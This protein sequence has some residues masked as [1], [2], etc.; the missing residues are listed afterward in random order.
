MYTPVLA[1]MLAAV[2]STT[3]HQSVNNPLAR[4]GHSQIDRVLVVPS[5]ESPPS[6]TAVRALSKRSG[7]AVSRL[8]L[9]E[10]LTL[11]GARSGLQL[12]FSP[13]FFPAEA[14]ISCDCAELTVSEALEEMLKG[15]DLRYLVVVDHVLI[16]AADPPID[17]VPSLAL[18][19]VATPAAGDV[20][21]TR[22]R[23]RSVVR[24][25][26]I[27]GRVFDSRTLQPIGTAQVFIPATGIGVLTRAD[28]TYALANVP[29]GPQTVQVQ[30]I[31]YAVASQIVDVAT[32]QSF[33]V[34]FELFRE[35]L[36]LNEIVVTG[37]AGGTQRRAVGNVVERMDLGQIRETSPAAT[38][39]QA[40][41]AKVP[42]M[43]VIPGSG[44][45]GG[46][47]AAIRIR[48][49]SSA[50]LPNDP[51]IYVDGIRINSDRA[52]AGSQSAGSRLNDINPADIESIEVI[53]GPAAATLYGTEASNGV[54]QIIT[55]R[56]Q[57]GAMVIDASVETGAAWF[58]DPENRI[59]TNYGRHPVTGELI[60][61]N[62]YLS[63][64]E[65]LGRDLYQRGP[66]RRYNLSARGGTDA[67]Q[68]FISGGNSYREGIVHWNW[69]KNYNGRGS[70]TVR[71]SESFAT[72]VNFSY[73]NGSNR[74][75]G[76][77]WGGILW[78]RPNTYEGATGIPN[79]LRGWQS[80]PPE[81]WENDQEDKTAVDRTT[82]SF[83][84]RHQPYPWLTNRVMAGM[85]LTDQVRTVL[86]FRDPDGEFGGVASREGRKTVDAIDT[87]IIT[88]DYAGT[89]SLG[90]TDRVTSAT[91]WGLQFYNKQIAGQ[92]SR[93]DNLATRSLTTVG[94][95][96]VTYGSE[97]WLENSTAGLY[98]QEQVD[99]DQRIFLTGAVRFDDNSAFG[100][101]FDIATYPKVSATW[102]VHEESFWNI[103]LISQFRLRSAWGAAGQQ[104][105]A[106]AATR[107]YESVTGPGD[108]PILVPL[109]Y[110]NSELGPERGEE[111]EVGF[112]ASGLDD[113]VELNFT[114]YTKK[115]SDA[116]VARPLP[117]SSGFR[118]TQLMNLGQVSN[119]GTE[120][121]LNM[122]L[123]QQR[124]VAWDL[125]TAFTTMHNRIDDMGD[126]E[127][128]PVRRAA[129]HVEGYPLASQFH[130]KIL[131]AD[132]VS[133]NSGAVTNLM[134]DGGA[135]PDGLRM[136]GPAVPCAEAPLVYFG[137]GE[138]TW[139]TAISSTLTL[140]DNWRLYAQV[141]G[142]GGSL[143]AH[144]LI[145]GAHTTY[146]NTLASQEQTDPIYMGYRALRRDP[147]SL[148]DG[149]FLK[150]REVSI[151]YT[152]PASLAA[153]FGANRA[154]INVAGRNLATIW[155]ADHFMPY[156]GMAIPD[157]EQAATPS[158]GFGGEVVTPIPPLR[159]ALVT[160]NVSF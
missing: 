14:E 121:Q 157:P 65:H 72:T 48:G 59:P 112:D 102:V 154:S 41:G 118:G 84:A 91:S 89:L 57:T 104:P 30:R 46:D 25:G 33:V 143:Q 130:Y 66:I 26:T 127:R 60:S 75:P 37:T 47:A 115:T 137:A 55:K 148:Y 36:E 149:S 80:N 152:L 144:D 52:Y 113:R 71:P 12:A 9:S 142:Q 85:D 132:F 58:H 100:S 28:G 124:R 4:G 94:A 77:I 24:N 21:A 44:E 51:I 73:M 53:K 160:V 34:D 90:L 69:E 62:I 126:I 43:M 42:G 79:N 81:F 156:G 117:P 98:I 63:E 86:N 116:I 129:S 122:R 31:G 99:W 150:L 128:I 87:R 56:G 64:R 70:I 158:V 159:Q 68:Y 3:E 23:P 61:Q 133:G 35:A 83:E 38:L 2:L 10:A 29:P 54:I 74:A 22:A 135:G 32:G 78:G 125:N 17:P 119:W 146:V 13:S 141:D 95:A 93:G 138:P 123:L 15:T 109:A 155:Q 96:A 27:T 50:A 120:T 82:F 147:I 67:V 1:V 18:A 40:I 7:F 8:R 20:L 110:G 153:R 92:Y 106:F 145:N 88:L 140:F 76:S 39:E 97:T 134:C 136:G 101:D 49:S 139:S 111:L 108:Q 114:Y 105:D 131:S 107:L 6:A 151:G 5:P 19:P 11:L 103:P 16:T 45:P